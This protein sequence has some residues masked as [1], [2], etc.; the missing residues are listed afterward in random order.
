MN[1]III[2]GCLRPYLVFVLSEI[3]PI[4]GSVIASIQRAIN[5][6]NPASPGF[7]PIILL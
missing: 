5:I 6:A 1:E 4:R 7:K 2:Y 3:V